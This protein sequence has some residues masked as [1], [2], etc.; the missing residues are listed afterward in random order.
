[1]VRR[2][3]VLLLVLACWGGGAVQALPLPGA[4]G[5]RQQVAVVVGRYTNGPEPTITAQEWVDLLKNLANDYF[6]L[7]TGGATSFEF[8]AVSG[9]L[10]FAEPLPA[11]LGAGTP[12]P[13]LSADET[14][15]AALTSVEQSLL[16]GQQAATYAAR[17][18]IDLSTTTRLVVFTGRDSRAC[19][20]IGHW[21]V[22]KDQ[23]QRP[24]SL[25]VAVVPE[26]QAG[27]SPAFDPAVALAPGVLSGA[28]DALGRVQALLRAGNGTMAMATVLHEMGHSLGLHVLAEGVETVQQL[29][30]LRERGC[31][32]YQGYLRSR[33]V[34]A[35]DFAA[36]LREQAVAV[37]CP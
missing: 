12:Q 8:T 19:S 24:V 36:L 29:Q 33:P 7:A 35:A 16:D 34:P 21:L 4:R 27:S 18:G 25:S 32:S 15:R 37:A 20:T 5:H 30:F 23:L 31:D 9:T 6:A 1:M 17:R 3:A 10:T 28:T 11:V 22:Y 2:P 14:I 26:I 13:V